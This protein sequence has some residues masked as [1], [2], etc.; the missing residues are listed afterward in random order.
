MWIVRL[1]LQRPYTF[2]VF[3]V[4]IVLMTPIVLQRT[5][6]DIFPEIDIPVISIAW[7]YPGLSPEQM[8]DR[9]V[10]NYERFMTTVVN[11]IEH[12]ES[13]TVAGRS[14]I[15]AFFQPGTNVPMAMSQITAISQ[16]AIRQLPPGTSPPLIITYSASAVPI[17]QL[18]LKGQGLS[19]QELFD[20]AANLVRNQMATV[21]GTAIPWPYGGKQRQ[22][23]VN[24]DI[25]ALQAKGLSPVDVINAMSLQNLALPGG[26]VKMGPT[27]FNVELNGSTNTIAALNDLPIKRSNGATIYVRD[28]ASVSDGFSPQINIVRMDGQRGVLVTI[29]KTGGAS[30]LDIVKNIYAKLPRLTALLPS[31]LVM[32]PL[33]DQSIFV[34]A[35]I[36]GVIREGVIAAC[37]TGLMVL[38]FL[39]NWRSTLI[40]AISIPLSVLVSLTVL[41]M[42]HETINIMTLGGLALAVGIL[43]DDATVEIENINRNLAQGKETVRAILDGAQEI[44]VPALVSTLAICIVFVPM[45]FLTGVAKFLFVPLAEAVVFAMLASYLLSRTLVPT[46]AMY[47]LRG[48]HGEEHATG[49]DVFSRIQRRF[50]LGFERMRGSYQAALRVC[51]DHAVMFTVLS[52]IF[53]VASAPV[54]LVLGRDFF[55][56]VDAG[57]IRLHMR[58]RA[59]QRVEE[60]ARESDRVDNLIRRVIPPQDLANVLDNIGL[61]NSIINTTYSNSGVIGESDAEILVGLKPE[62]RMATRYYVDQLRERLAEEFPGTQFFFQPADIVSQI[63][64]FGVPAPV[65]IQLIGPDQQ[66]NYRLAQQITNRVQRIPGAVDVHVQ[67]LFSN[68]ALF[69]DVDRARALS[70]GLTQQDVANSILLTLSSS[71]Q[72]DPSFWV[73]PKNGFEYN[74][75]VQVPQYK[76]DSLET[77]ENIPVSSTSTTTPQVLANLARLSVNVEPAL[78]THYN[79]QPM[80]DVYASV[81]GRD[82]GGVDAEIQGVLKDFLRKL[83]RGTQLE[84]RGQVAA[85][86]SSFTGLAA[87]VGVAIVLVYM[88]IVVNFQSWIDPF[89]I[90]TALPGAMAGILWMLLVTHSTL[91]VP[92]LTGMIMSIG[93]ATANSIL[94]VSFARERLHEGRNAAQAALEAGYVRIRPVLMTALAMIIGMLPMSLGLGEGGEQNAPLGRAVIGGLIVATFATLFFVPCVFSLVHR[95]YKPGTPV[96]AAGAAN[97]S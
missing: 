92:S 38:L 51:L 59:G 70:V 19:E 9:I 65:D 68:P 6:T 27:E 64:N 34:R 83:P 46:L 72:I 55:P 93:V 2:I 43:V 67:Q 37:L 73:N 29:Y 40:I 71:F 48:Q 97:P 74:V 14:V 21:P 69:L 45:F 10:S 15:K 52:L 30:T 80:I 89:I 36:Q 42:L 56:S 90:I 16:T 26:T 20:Y 53:C 95:R 7:N 23:S 86:T 33:F 76:I 24:V 79:N 28:V 13:Q 84:R 22:V 94:M 78:I 17:L 63:L 1:A 77:V 87:G 49:N 12:I 31:Q 39:G 47:L 91:S 66:A 4:V 41:S 44:A 25:P 82:L 35:A 88:L 32:T 57:L 3:A 5:P 50:A 8:E 61:F 11:N 18:G 96:M 81:E 62:H 58:A 85:M 75:A 60:T 54:A